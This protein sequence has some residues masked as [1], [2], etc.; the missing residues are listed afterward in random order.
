MIAQVEEA[1][2]R[3]TRVPGVRGCLMIGIADGLV[4]AERLMDGVDGAAVAALS[5]SVLGRLS[6]AVERAGLQPP[7]FVHLRGEQGSVLAC[8]AADDLLL[9]AV[10]RAQADLGSI[11]LELLAAARSLG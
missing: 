9:V 7:R 3:V 1:I 11:R 8:P 2:E 5:G 10:T 4:V 6:R